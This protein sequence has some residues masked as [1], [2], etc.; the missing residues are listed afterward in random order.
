MQSNKLARKQE[1]NIVGCSCSNVVV[2][3]EII[4]TIE[5]SLLSLATIFEL[6]DTN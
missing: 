6:K 3:Y 1:E 4:I 5:L 2:V